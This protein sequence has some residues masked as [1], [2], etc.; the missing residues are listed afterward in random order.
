MNGD[1]A[2]AVSVSITVRKRGESF[3]ACLPGSLPLTL[4]GLRPG[5]GRWVNEMIYG[6]MFIVVLGPGGLLRVVG[7]RFDAEGVFAVLLVVERVALV[8]S[9][10][11]QSI[12]R[13]V[14][15]WMEPDR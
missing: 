11:V 14:T 7:S 8:C 4:T 6:E 3:H 12:E 5:M 13:R 1:L 9:F 15:R 10:V 2:P